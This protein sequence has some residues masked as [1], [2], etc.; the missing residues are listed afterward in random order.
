MVAIAQT[1]AR[2][3]EL[4]W[5]DRLALKLLRGL[6]VVFGLS[7]AAVWVTLSGLRERLSLSGFI[8]AMAAV[9]ALPVFTGRPKGVARAWLVIGPAVAMSLAGY[10]F[11][12]YVSGCGASLTV[13]MLLAGL[14]LG[15]RAMIML[16]FACAMVLGLIAWAMV[17]GHLAAPPPADSSMVSGV[18]WTRSLAMTFVAIAL[19]CGLIVAVVTRIEQALRFAR[20]ETLRRQ[21]AERVAYEAR[22]LELVGRLAAGIAHDFNNNLTSIMGCAELLQ[23]EHGVSPE[24]TDNILRSSQRLAELTRQ[25]LAYS[26]KGRMVRAPVDLHALLDDVVSLL[27]RSTDPNVRVVTDLEAR[28]PVVAAD[29]ALLQSAVLNLLVNARDAMPAGGTITVAT[30]TLEL[31]SAVGDAEG[32][33]AG[34]CVALEVRDT[35]EGI[36][37]EVLPQIFDPFFTTKPL[38][39]GTGLGLAA[40]A[41]TIK[42]HGGRIDVESEPGAGTSFRVTLPAQAEPE[43]AAA[44]G[45]DDEI[46]RGDGHVLLV[47][48]DTLVSRT[49][50]ATLQSFGY[51]V[52]HASDGATAVELVRGAPRAFDVVLLDLRMPGM[53]GEDTFAALKDA[54]PDLKILIWSGYGA[55]Q[56]VSS[57]LRRGAAGFVQKPYGAASLSRTLANVL[58]R[59]GRG[60]D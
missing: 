37:P 2:D 59:P 31:P 53:T 19:F 11:A 28:H 26:R 22:Q 32:G 34:R 1:A 56:D 45:R 47:D 17:N 43:R 12:G 44:A 20:E 7:L 39:R 16:L 49:A 21:Q 13:T 36:A 33:P 54:A 24:L 46:V 38:G 25:L 18:A 35:G 52:T 10:A 8:V 23:L 58:R 55:E 3:E 60:A 51:R 57:M 6:L 4:E 40:V 30:S 42:A 5:R 14:L 50:V 27:R 29:A 41:G 48:D 9:L 15:R